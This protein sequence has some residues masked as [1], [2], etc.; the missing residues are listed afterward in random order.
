MTRCFFF[1]EKQNSLHFN[2]KWKHSI[3]QTL[4]S[5]HR[6]S[7]VGGR[8]PN[9]WEVWMNGKNWKSSDLPITPIPQASQQA[10][11]IGICCLVWLSKGSH[12]WPLT[13]KWTSYHCM[14]YKITFNKI[15]NLTLILKH[16]A[17]KR[18]ASSYLIKMWS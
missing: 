1:P 3:P 14:E 13:L 5:Y 6:I 16:G 4:K 11:L 9:A 17:T 18:K 10:L 15:Q 2:I 8:T 12:P 7:K